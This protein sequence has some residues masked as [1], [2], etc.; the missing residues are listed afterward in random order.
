MPSVDPSTGRTAAQTARHHEVTTL[1]WRAWNDGVLAPLEG[2][3]TEEWFD[4][5][6]DVV[7]WLDDEAPGWLD[8]VRDDFIP[9]WN[10]EAEDD[11]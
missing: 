9:G 1:M 7:G 5:W 4:A 2:I 10:S 6:T 8:E 3:T 11:G